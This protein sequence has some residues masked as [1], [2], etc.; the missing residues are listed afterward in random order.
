MSKATRDAR[1]IDLVAAF[2][3]LGPAWSRWVQATVPDDSVSYARLRVLTALE[4]WVDG[5]W[6]VVRGI[7]RMGGVSV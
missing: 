6:G 1:L 2:G 4:W 7:L 5:T 3:E